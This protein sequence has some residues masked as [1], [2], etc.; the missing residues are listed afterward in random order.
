MRPWELKNDKYA[1]VDKKGQGIE[2]INGANQEIDKISFS[3]SDD[4]H[5]HAEVRP[6]SP[7]VS[8]NNDEIVFLIWGS[9]AEDKY[10][11]I[12]L[13]KVPCLEC[14]LDAMEPK[15]GI[16]PYNIGYYDVIKYDL[17]T[18][19]SSTLLRTVSD[20]SIQSPIW[21][22]DQSKI[23]FFIQE[24]MYS[25]ELSTAKIVLMYDVSAD[26]SAGTKFDYA[27]FAVDGKTI[28]AISD[29]YSSAW[30]FGLDGPITVLKKYDFKDVNLPFSN[31]AFKGSYYA[32][33]IL[34][35]EAFKVLPDEAIKTLFS[36]PQNPQ[37][38]PQHCDH[39]SYSFSRKHDEGYFPRTEWIDCFDRKNQK[40]YKI[41]VINRWIPSLM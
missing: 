20:K 6:R 29:N 32:Y 38:E 33:R 23:Y 16:Y 3:N 4:G 15:R 22:P 26:Q 19:K 9:I 7:Q 8:P 24:R 5:W 34:S 2:V 41:R 10:N 25:Y 13:G 37:I 18:K 40:H 36:D 35:D 1:Y 14:D 21:S 28:W 17:G 39:Y 31:N 11:E 27:R 12:K 30:Q